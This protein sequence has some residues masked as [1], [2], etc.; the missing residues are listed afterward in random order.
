MSKEDSSQLEG[1]PIGKPRD[2]LN[3]KKNSDC[4]IVEREEETFI[5][6]LNLR[7]TIYCRNSVCRL[8]AWSGFE[9]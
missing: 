5:G 7:G 3:I 6:I 4:D 9:S 1:A 2:Y 8:R